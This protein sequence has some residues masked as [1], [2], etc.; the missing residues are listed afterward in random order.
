[1]ERHAAEK[2]AIKQREAAADA[3]W[4]QKRG[5]PP[6]AAPMQQRPWAIA[7]LSLPEHAAVRCPLSAPPIPA[8]WLFTAVSEGLPHAAAHCANVWAVFGHCAG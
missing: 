4:Q 2:E 8:A 3:R 6:S 7:A 1:M 5:L